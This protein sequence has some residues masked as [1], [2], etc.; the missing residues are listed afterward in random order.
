VVVSAILQIAGGDRHI[1]ADRGARRYGRAR[2]QCL[3]FAIRPSVALTKGLR[4]H[5]QTG[6]RARDV[7]AGLTASVT[8]GSFLAG[9][10]LSSSG[11]P[12]A[13][14]SP[15]SGVAVS[16]IGCRGNVDL[17]KALLSVI[18]WH[19]FTSTTFAA[20]RHPRLWRRPIHAVDFQSNKSIT[21][22]AQE[23]D[24]AKFALSAIWATVC[25]LFAIAGKPS[26]PASIT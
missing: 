24:R 4:V 23:N 12:H 1:T 3:R 16:G 25:G 9:S 6:D 17:L 15:R 5:L 2:W 19:V 26:Q 13:T 18:D 11:N 8:D 22:P 21:W 20:L 10:G 7:G 14:D